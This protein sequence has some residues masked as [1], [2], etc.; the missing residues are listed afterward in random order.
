MKGEDVL[1]LSGDRGRGKSTVLKEL[2]SFARERDTVIGGLLSLRV[3]DGINTV[4][5]PDNAEFPLARYRGG[6]PK[7]IVM[8]PYLFSP[9]V[10]DMAN[11]HLRNILSRSTAVPAGVVID[12][13]GPLEL[14]RN[15]GFLPGL[16]WLLQ[17]QIPLAIVIRPELVDRLAGLVG[18]SGRKVGPIIDDPRPTGRVVLR[19]FEYITT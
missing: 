8:G 16:T 6:A 17:Q 18:S 19:L 7:G 9:A 14:K 2:V 15:A 1:F 12:E 4:F 3:P 11:S 13:I 10:I 5:L